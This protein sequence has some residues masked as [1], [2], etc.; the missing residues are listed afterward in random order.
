MAT[1]LREASGN[2]GAPYATGE[3]VEAILYQARADAGRFL[4]L[5]GRRRDLRRQ[6]DDPRLRALP[7]RVARLARGRQDPRQPPRPR[8]RRRP[9]GR[10]RRRPRLRARLDRRHRRSSPRPRRPRAQARRPRARRGVRVRLERR[11]LDH[12][13]EAGR[14][15]RAR[16]P[17]RSRGSTPCT[18][19]RTSPSTSRRSAAT[20]CS[21]RR[22]SSAG[23]T[24][25][26]PTDGTTCS[27]P[28]GPTRRAPPSTS[29]VGRRF[30]TG[31]APYELLA[32][33]S[34]TIAYLDSLGGL[35]PLRD[36]ER[37]LGRRFLD[38]AARTTSPSTA[39]RRWRVA[40]RRS[41]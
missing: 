19:R 41:C 27:S 15:A 18:T 21:A 14:R 12:R 33:F 2:L 34:A 11:R 32:G 8:R 31:T 30:E 39:C 28:G 20:C 16:T 36:Y 9:V 1:A 17:A 35:E 37:E 5:L 29:P 6:H 4:E 38:G 26:W 10:A 7:H 23:R 3:R 40:C 22:T 13:R 25:A 24:W